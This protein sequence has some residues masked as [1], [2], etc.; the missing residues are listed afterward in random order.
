MNRIMDDLDFMPAYERQQAEALLKVFTDLTK[1]KIYL[2]IRS[3]GCVTREE[4]ETELGLKKT[5][6]L[7]HLQ[8]LVDA[9]VVEVREKRKQTKVGRP[10]KYYCVSS[11]K[12]SV[13]LNKQK[14]LQGSPEVVKNYLDNYFSSMVVQFNLHAQ[15]VH[16]SVNKFREEEFRGCSLTDS[17]YL[18][19][20]IGQQTFRRPGLFVVVGGEEEM[21]IVERKLSEALVEVQMLK[22]RKK[23]LGSKEKPEKYQF[24]AN[25]FPLVGQVDD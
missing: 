5:A 15:Q 24:F 11:K 23:S 8:D 2:F 17:G 13:T 4:L 9:M 10:R 6:I 1:T 7:H 12:L 19:I 18:R 20:Q 16:A 25:I 21:A 14:V 3:K 22:E